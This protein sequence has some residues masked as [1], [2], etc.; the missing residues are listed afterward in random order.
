MGGNESNQRYTDEECLT[1]FASLFP[2]GFAGE[3]VLAEIAPEGWMDSTLHFVFHPTLDQVHWER[4]QLH[5][6][7]REWRWRSKDGGQEP[8]PSLEDV[9]ATY[10]DG[11]VETEHEVRELVAMC[12]WDVFSNEHDVVDR[13]G[14]LVDIGSWRGAAGFLAEQLNRQTGE[15]RYDYMDF[16]MGS[17]GV[18]QRADLMPVYE[19]VFRR[20]KE[21]WLD[22]RY[23]F[24][25]VQLIEFPS[26]RPN[27]ARSYQ[28]EKM[29]AELR[30]AHRQAIED[31]KLEPA[32]EIVLA[33]R[34]VYGVLPHGWPP[35]EF[36]Q[37]DD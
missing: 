27:G 16:Y 3:D 21:R 24:P 8:E 1:L 2:K 17:F 20:L 33:Y 36:N 23:S 10:G 25:Q 30:E 35:W 5:R 18:S 4:V 34:N 13:D 37:R 19:M 29:K 28:L 9:R 11:P 15:S 22:W 14:R 7:L 31:S 12:L 6:N 26:E 32:P